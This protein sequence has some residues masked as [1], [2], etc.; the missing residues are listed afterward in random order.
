MRRR[1]LLLSGAPGPV[2]A[3]RAAQFGRARAGRDREALAVT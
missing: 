1:F 2:A 3:V